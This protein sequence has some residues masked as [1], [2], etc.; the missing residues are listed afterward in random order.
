MIQSAIISPPLAAFE[1]PDNTSLTV[2]MQDG[3]TQTNLWVARARMQ[4]ALA[5]ASGEASRERLWFDPAVEWSAP[6][7]GAVRRLLL[8]AEAEFAREDGMAAQLVALAA[9]TDLFFRTALRELPHNGCVRLRCP[10]GDCHA[11]TPAAEAFMWVQAEARINLVEIAA[12]AGCSVRTVQNAF[13]LFRD[14][15]PHRALQ[16]GRLERAREA[17]RLG[18]SFVFTWSGASDTP[19]VVAGGG[20]DFGTLGA[21]SPG[22]AGTAGSRGSGANGSADGLLGES[23][24]GTTGFIGD[25]GG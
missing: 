17:L 18:G 14:T 21:G 7:P 19:F 5:A 25:G 22:Q 20:G 6:R 15:T 1:Q 16:G 13:R 9:F 24:V 10:V 3:T 12:A 11:E 4:T 2:L 8:Y 23:G